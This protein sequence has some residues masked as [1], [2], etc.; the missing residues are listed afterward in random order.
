[1]AQYI[2]VVSVTAPAQAQQGTRVDVAMKLKN[3]YSVPISIYG[4]ITPW[5]GTRVLLVTYLTTQLGTLNPGATMDISGYFTMPGVNVTVQCW[6]YWYGSDDVYHFDDEKI[7]TVTLQTVA[8]GTIIAKTINYD[9]IS[10]PIPSY[11]IR[12]GSSVQL[13]VSVRNDM[14]SAQRLGIAIVVVTPSGAVVYTYT[15]WEEWPY[16]GAGN[17][18][19]FV[20][21]PNFILG[22]VGEYR[23]RIDAYVYPEGTVCIDS[24][25]GVLCTVIPQEIPTGLKNTSL[26]VV[27]DYYDYFASV[28]Y[29][30][31]YEYKGKAQG[32]TIQ[33]ELGT[34]VAPWFT[35]EV[36]LGPVAYSFAKKDDWDWVAQDRSFMLPDTV[37][38]GQTY[39]ARVTLRT[40]DGV[41]DKDTD[42]TALRVVDPAV[43]ST[44]LKDLAII[45]PYRDYNL[46]EKLPITLSY[47]YK[48]V[49]QSGQ[50][51][52]LI[53]KGV[54]FSTAYTYP[55]QEI[56]FDRADALATVTEDIE[57]TL[58]LTLDPG[59]V[60]SVKIVLETSDGKRDDEV[61]GSAFK[62]DSA[63]TPEDPGV[64]EYRVV[65]DYAYPAA[66][67]YVGEA[68][69]C[70]YEFNIPMAQ[71]PG[72]DWISG[73]VIDEHE[74][75]A[76]KHGSQMLHLKVSER[77]HGLTSKDYLVVATATVP[78]E[79]AGQEYSTQGI[80]SLRR[81]TPM[82]AQVI[83][84]AI[85][86]GVLAIIFIF[87]VAYTIKETRAFLWGEEGQPPAQ[88]G[89][90]VG[91]LLI[92]GLM[93]AMVTA[94]PKA[95]E[96]VETGTTKLVKKGREKIKEKVKWH[97]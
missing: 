27:L 81:V 28:P 72:M 16:T 49:T 21:R 78:E 7:A 46:G 34:G 90:T 42:Y 22:T 89:E 82:F 20:A 76:K 92:M 40:A 95:T 45:T 55:V 84:A 14:T 13:R 64:G 39:S 8:S 56:T 58:P 3:I 94:M 50:M 68:S 63:A 73:Q 60:Y 86:L 52:V 38:R 35:P 71:M 96:W 44:E 59:Q 32:G 87:G 33:V 61:K 54:I 65:K 6:G 41:E 11:N 10:A 74:E 5:D 18:H 53:G 70:T 15:D 29:V 85:I 67:T 80:V 79:T 26:N 4:V 75:E 2:E 69:Q 51:S 62:I 31:S 57:V 83:W 91:V 9:G 77:D 43:P 24:Y 12:Q 36:A 93:M 47:R 97:G 48:G 25:D 1:M 30:L 23:I 66:E 17:T 37:R 88:W 19:E